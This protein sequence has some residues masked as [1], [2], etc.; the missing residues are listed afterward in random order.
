MTLASVTSLI[1]KSVVRRYHQV[2]W[3]ILSI[4]VYDIQYEYNTFFSLGS[5]HCN[6]RAALFL[7]PTDPFTRTSSRNMIQGRS[8]KMSKRR[9]ML[10]TKHYL[11]I[12]HWNKCTSNMIPRTPKWRRSAVCNSAEDKEESALSAPATASELFTPALT[13]TDHSKL[14]NSN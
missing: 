9:M 6:Q 12:N 5:N 1:Q 4:V 10:E 13:G 14:G 11:F 7:L 2:T 3:T 8:K